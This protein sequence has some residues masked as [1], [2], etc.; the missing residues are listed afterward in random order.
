MASHTLVIS[1]PEIRRL[2]GNRPVLKVIRANAEELVRHE[3]KLGKI[4]KSSG[5]SVWRKL[6][7]LVS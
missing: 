7:E 6:Q 5:G 3:T 1:A 4:D 2:D